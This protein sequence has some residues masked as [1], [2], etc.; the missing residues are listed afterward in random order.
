MWIGSAR[1]PHP[2]TRA[3]HLSLSAPSSQSPGTDLGCSDAGLLVPGDRE[4]CVFGSELNAG[5]V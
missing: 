5:R 3:L 1:T 4:A 2:V